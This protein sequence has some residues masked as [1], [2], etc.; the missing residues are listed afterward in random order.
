M[1]R[2]HCNKINQNTTLTTKVDYL[3]DHPLAT[4]GQ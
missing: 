2:H 1:A 3:P 4:K